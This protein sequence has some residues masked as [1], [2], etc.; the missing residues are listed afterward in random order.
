MADLGAWGGDD[1]LD[2]GLDD[3]A[4][5]SPKAAGHNFSSIGYQT[6]L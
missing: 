1:D 4:E 5:A 2:L 6:F 3:V